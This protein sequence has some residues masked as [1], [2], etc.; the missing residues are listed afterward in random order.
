MLIFQMNANFESFYY[1][2]KLTRGSLIED[3]SNYTKTNA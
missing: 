3:V 2:A 1:F